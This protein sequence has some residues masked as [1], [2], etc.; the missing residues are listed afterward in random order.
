VKPFDD[1]EVVTMDDGKKY[2]TKCTSEKTKNHQGETSETEGT[3]Y[4][5]LSR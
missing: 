3:G 4:T 5:S 2:V 1:F